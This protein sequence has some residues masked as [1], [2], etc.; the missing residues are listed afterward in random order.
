MLPYREHQRLMTSWVAVLIGFSMLMSTGVVLMVS[1][2]SNEMGMGFTFLLLGIMALLFAL[3][4]FAKLEIV[5]DQ[6]GVQWRW[7]P[8]HRTFRKLQWEEIDVAWI[9]KYNALKEYGGW[10]VKG[11]RKNRAFN[12]SG[13]Q[14]LQLVLHT[15]RKI[16]LET[17]HAHA[18][19]AALDSLK[20]SG[21]KAI[22]QNHE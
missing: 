13:N 18:M 16:L 11:T 22:I 17:K 19:Q 9:R 12:I 5:I 15:G 7:F 2:T 10:G 14:G 8:I 3:F 1:F 20:A 21:I 4:Y 6:V